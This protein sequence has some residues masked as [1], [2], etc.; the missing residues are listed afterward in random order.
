MERIAS[1]SKNPALIIIEPADL[2]NSKAL[3]ISQQ[4]LVKKGYNVYSPCSFIWGRS[5]S[6]I[7]CWS[8][9]EPGNIKVPGFMEKIAETADS[10]RYLNTD[11]KFS[12]VILRRNGLT[13][14]V[15]RAKGKFMALA[16]LKKH[17]K[18]HINVAASV[19]SGNL[20]DEK[21]FVFKICDGTA[22][23]PCYAVMPAYHISEINMALIEAGYGDIV[24][25]SGTLVRENMEQ[26]SFNLFI[27]RNTIV[28]IVG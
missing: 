9:Q 14:H 25:I 22:S 26:S 15:Y 11:M 10:Y 23:S 3:R 20:G 27:T 17:I 5:C 18:K 8:F 7:N 12:S 6:G 13:R 2:D 28:N 19:M 24:E 21:I 16:N 1:S 4:A